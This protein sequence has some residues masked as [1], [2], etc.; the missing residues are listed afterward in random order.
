[1]GFI[2]MFDITSERSFLNVRD[3]ISQLRTHAYCES[4]DIVLVGNKVDTEDRRQ[5]QQTRAKQFAESQG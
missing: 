3:W 2:V 4:P 5:V 1:M